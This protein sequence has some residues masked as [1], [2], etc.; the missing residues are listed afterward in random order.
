MAG[1]VITANDEYIK[2][3][4]IYVIVNNGTSNVALTVGTNAKLFTATVESGAIQKISEASVDNAFVNGTYNSTAK[5]YTVT[6]AAGKNLVLTDTESTLLSAITSIA[7]TDSPTGNAITVNGAKFRP[8]AAGTY[9]FQYVKT[10]PVAATPG[11][12]QYKVIK[13]KD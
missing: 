4:D 5:T 2:G 3:N 9:V 10:A 8:T 12:Y 7:D 13:V 1:Q 11:E 6:D